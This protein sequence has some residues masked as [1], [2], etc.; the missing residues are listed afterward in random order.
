MLILNRRDFLKNATAFGALAA[1]GTS[2]DESLVTARNG[3]ANWFTVGGNGLTIDTLG[4]ASLQANLGGSG[5]VTKAGAG[6]L[7]VAINQTA[8]AAFNVA[9]GTLALAGGVTM[10]RALAVADGATLS[11]DGMAQT[12]VSNV[13]FAAGSTLDVASYVPGVVPLAVATSATLPEGGTVMVKV[14]AADGI[15]PKGGSYALTSGGK[16]TNANVSLASGAPNWVKGVSVADG[17]IV[18][19]V[20]PRGFML[21]VK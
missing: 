18:L 3:D 15:R 19:E 5:A 10:G 14:S 9:E 7:T 4:A 8:A 20:K 1:T 6:T 11:L 13:A 17:E 16:F 12:T 2:G 21:I